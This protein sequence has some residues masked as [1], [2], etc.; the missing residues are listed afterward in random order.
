MGKE[1][2][3]EEST[4]KDRMMEIPLKDGWEKNVKEEYILKTRKMIEEAE[5]ETDDDNEGENKE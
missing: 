4:L 5:E 3:N 2:E 1:K